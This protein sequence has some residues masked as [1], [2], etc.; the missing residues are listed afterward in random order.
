MRKSDDESGRL[1]PEELREAG[2]ALFG[3]RWQTPLA[4]ALNVHDNS[5]I[6]EWMRGAR[7]IPLGVRQDVVRLLFAASEKAAAL[8]RRLGLERRIIDKSQS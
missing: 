7:P 3:E 4:A 8:A 5:R 6:R 2:V 1:S